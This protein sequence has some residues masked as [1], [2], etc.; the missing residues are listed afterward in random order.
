M[1]DPEDRL[2]LLDALRPPPGYSFD[3]AVGTTFTLDL[4]ALL[5]TP[6]AFALF[7]VEAE[8][9]RIAANPIAVLESVRR[10]ASRITV[11]TQAGLIRV[12]P[13]FRIAYAYLERSVVAVK[14]PRPGGIFHPKVWVIRFKAPD[15]DVRLRFLCLSRNLTFDRSWD[16]VLRLDGRPTGQ[17]NDL[18]S[19]I[20]TFLTALPGL[21]ID[22][23]TPER[24][25]PVTELAAEVATAEW[26]GLPEGLRLERMWPIGHDG[27]RAWPFPAKSWRRLVV[28]PFVEAG[29][30]ERFTDPQRGDLLV[31]RAETL[32]AIGAPSL[33]HLGRRLVLRDEALAETDP[34]E[35]P[36]EPAAEQSLALTT[37]LQGLHAKLFVVDD[38]WWSHIWTGSA[39]ATDAAFNANVEFLVELKGRNTTHCAGCLIS[40][41]EGK[42]VGFGRLLEDWPLR[43]EPVPIAADEEAARALERLAMQLGSLQF[44]AEVGEPEDEMYPLRLTGR[45]DLRVLLP[46]TGEGLSVAVRPLS[47]GGAW[48]VKPAVDDGVL[49]AEWR[50]SFDS[51]TAFF[52]LDLVATRG[53]MVSNASFVVQAQL[54]GEPADRLQRVLAAELKNRSDLVRLLLMLL[55]GTDSAFGGLVDLLTGDRIGG[56]ENSDLI[57]GSEALLEPLMRTFARNPARLDEIGAL[58]TELARTDE[59]RALLPEGW[60][61]VWASIEAARSARQETPA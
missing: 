47:R 8:D 36:E 42:A 54:L 5:V 3:R 18:S 51:L 48:A 17:Q 57:L 31:S 11:F 52:V 32:D 28:A 58:V 44:V 37:E 26:D 33:A 2:L 15:D 59:G 13:A 40:A 1:L 22:P 50:V 38:A 60:R 41:P 21:A 24:S 23:M 19:P 6:V 49:T 53:S 55:G 27:Q 34:P 16:T 7:D 45:G 46:R 14:A 12:P 9:G 25:S 4:V 35:T 61:E 20:G 43:E 56:Q 30:L 10:F 39:N 29:F